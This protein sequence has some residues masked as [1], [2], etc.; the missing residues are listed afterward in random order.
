MDKI[1]VSDELKSKILA[2]ADKKIKNSKIISFKRAAAA[3][4][5]LAVCI[6]VSGLMHGFITSRNKPQQEL[7]PSASKTGQ[8]K[9]EKNDN[10]ADNAIIGNPLPEDSNIPQP[11]KDA[12]SPSSRGEKKT[13]DNN[14]AAPEQP[15]EI[16]QPPTLTE[17]PDSSE[18]SA[19]PQSH[20]PDIPPESDEELETGVA[21]PPQSSD[22]AFDEDEIKNLRAELG[23]AFSIP[24]CIPDGYAAES[25]DLLFGSL[26]QLTY[27]SGE[28][29]LT[30]RTEKYDGDISGDYSAYEI[31]ENVS[32]GGADVTLRINGDKCYGAVWQTD[33]AYAIYSSAGLSREQAIKIIENI[34]Q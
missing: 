9:T 24:H 8:P 2:A 14:A 31:T 30:F 26:V 16:I 13:V 27:T 18:N 20:A 32:I 21:T 11:G 1:T 29:K 28:D 22:Y 34:G 25:A 10:I 7:K 12:E 4:A 15:N 19:P 6:S 33:S 17:Q 3:A 23:Y 5:G